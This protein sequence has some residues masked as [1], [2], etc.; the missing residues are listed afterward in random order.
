MKSEHRH[1][2]KTNDLSRWATQVGHST[3]KYTNQI[4]AGVLG[5]VLLAGIGIYWQSASRAARSAGWNEMAAAQSAEDFANIADKYPGT[6]VAAWATL[7]EG[8]L[9]L[10]TGMRLT[11]TDRASGVSDL[12]KS[13]EA[14]EKLVND[15]S[16]PADVKER[17]LFGLGRTLETLSDKNTEEA[18][19]AYQKLITEYAY[20]AYK[21][22]AE[23]RIAALRTGGAQD[24]YAWWHEQNP[25]PVDRELPRDLS[26]PGGPLLN[27]NN[28]SAP[29]GENE[30]PTTSGG[31]SD[32]TK[33]APSEKPAETSDEKPAE[34]TE[35]PKTPESDAKKGAET[36]AAS[37]TPEAPAKS[38][39]PAKK[40]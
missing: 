17:A 36:P 4:I 14:F 10:G 32:P 28:T 33:A 29:L 3:E 15:D 35:A 7:R 2:L 30:F 9:H 13:R 37:P 5:L 27:P 40:E 11:F 39:E 19:A 6:Q 34:K 16:V 26:T 38:D 25:K 22:A 8:E 31:T 24:F 12:K 20:S 1:E 18:I 21:N 23:A